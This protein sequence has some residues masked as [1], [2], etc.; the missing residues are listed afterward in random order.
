LK[1]AGAKPSISLKISATT[2]LNSSKIKLR[3]L[4]ERKKRR[5]TEMKS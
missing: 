5:T 2:V 4:S 1:L 3:K